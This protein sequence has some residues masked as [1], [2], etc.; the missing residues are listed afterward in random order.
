MIYR[1]SVILCHSETDTIQ[2]DIWGHRPY[3]DSKAFFVGVEI[4]QDDTPSHIE[5][6]LAEAAMANTVIVNYGGEFRKI[7]WKGAVATIVTAGNLAELN[8]ENP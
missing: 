8:R 3:L 6:A 7:Y 4:P 1:G 5:R 2:V